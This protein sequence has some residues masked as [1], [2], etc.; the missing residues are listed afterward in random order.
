MPSIIASQFYAQ[1]KSYCTNTVENDTLRRVSEDRSISDVMS[2]CDFT[3]CQVTLTAAALNGFKCRISYPSDVI[4][5]RIRIT[6]WL[7]EHMQ[8]AHGFHCA[9]HA[10]SALWRIN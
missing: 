3:V 6:P 2:A 1:T 9:E 8:A 10:T 4:N 7:I 5:R